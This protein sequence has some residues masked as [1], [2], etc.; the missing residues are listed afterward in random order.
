MRRRLSYALIIVAVAVGASGPVQ[1]RDHHNRDNEFARGALQRGEVLP[2][3]RVLA[4]AHQH[5]PGDVIGVRLEPHRGG[6]LTY[7]IRVLTPSGQIREVVLDARTGGF[8][9]IE[10]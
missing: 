5:I 10:E 4:L 1:A 3:E 9:K 2:V 8:L 7:D 6:G